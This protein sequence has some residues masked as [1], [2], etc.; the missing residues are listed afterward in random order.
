MTILLP[1]P[2]ATKLKPTIPPES[3]HLG[4][5]T[6]FACN[7]NGVGPTARSRQTHACR[8]NQTLCPMPSALHADSCSAH[9]R[10]RCPS[11]AT[12]SSRINCWSF[13]N[14]PSTPFGY[15]SGTSKSF[16]RM[17]TYGLASS[18]VGGLEEEVDWRVC[19]GALTLPFTDFPSWGTSSELEAGK[20]RDSPTVGSEEGAAM[21]PSGSERGSSSSKGGGK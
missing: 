3:G 12:S 6:F 15:A 1:A 4:P 9:K 8:S 13:T 10:Y 18:L 19:G 16:Q 2:P 20:A 11:Q 21:L 5:T 7:H 14:R 17:N